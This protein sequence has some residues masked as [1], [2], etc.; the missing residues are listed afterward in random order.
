MSRISEVSSTAAQQGRKLL[1]PYLVA[2]DPDLETTLKL[3]H[4]L[5]DDGADIIELGVPFSDPSSDGPVIQKG[6][7]RALS[8]GTTLVEVLALVADFRTTNKHTAIVLMGYLNPVERMGYAHFVEG[9]SSAGVDGVLIVDLPPSEASAIKPLMDAKGIDTI[10]LVAPTTTDARA[11]QIAAN[12]TGYLYYVSL[13][14]VTGAALIDT[15]SVRQ[16]IEKLRRMSDLPIVIGF[17]IKDAASAKAMGSIADGVIIGSALVEKIAELS[18]ETPYTVER[19]RAVSE[20]IR[21]ARGA[22]DER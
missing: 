10:F 6:V 15:E 8:R 11:A 3:M 14:G 5:V 22:L 16:S 17:G 21:L 18:G 9:A 12:C 7:E 13:K 20:V 1:I 19:L 4:Q 2:G